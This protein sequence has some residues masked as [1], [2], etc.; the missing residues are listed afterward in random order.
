M[1]MFA[2]E[3]PGFQPIGTPPTPIERGNRL[4]QGIDAAAWAAIEPNLERV[5]L[6]A[7]E[8][9]EE[10]GCRASFLYFPIRGA[11]SIEA[12]AGKKR[13][14]VALVGREGM[15]GTAL[16]LDGV[17]ANR[18]LVLFGGTTWRVPADRLAA[19]LEQDRALHSQLLRG[20]NAF[21]ARVSATALANGQGTIEQRLARWLLTAADRLDTNMLAISHNTLAQILGVR[22]AG[23]TVAL[24]VLE[25]R[26]ALR[27]ERRRVRILDREQLTLAAAP[28]RPQETLS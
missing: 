4:L 18:A 7:D 24:H 10:E 6:V 13:M 21:F 22:R 11:V 8:I 3:L 2:D 9:L 17:A 28:Y 25:G 12:A 26:H 23:V 16:L 1:T 27:S 20:V 19:C 5:A 15:V 14:Q